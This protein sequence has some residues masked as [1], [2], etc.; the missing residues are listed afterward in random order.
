MGVHRGAQHTDVP[1][2]DE[3]TRR[4]IEMQKNVVVFL[5][6]C[7]SGASSDVVFW[8]SWTLDHMKNLQ[9][10]KACTHQSEAPQGQDF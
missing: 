2:M 5:L 9:Q 6:I 7:R 10:C 3:L 8:V 4:F 1:E